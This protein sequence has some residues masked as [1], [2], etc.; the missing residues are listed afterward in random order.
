MK[1]G[2]FATTTADIK[3]DLLVTGSLQLRGVAEIEGGIEFP[4][5]T[6]MG[7][8]TTAPQEIS[9]YGIIASEEHFKSSRYTI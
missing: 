5:H 6:A 3:N 2:D 9:C 7:V 4:S 1:G 8:G